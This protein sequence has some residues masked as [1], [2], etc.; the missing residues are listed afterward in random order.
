VYKTLNNISPGMLDY[1]VEEVEKKLVP[2]LQKL[3]DF[4]HQMGI[5]VIYTKFSAFMQDG[6]DLPAPLQKQNKLAKEFLGDI[7]YPHISHESSEIIANLKP[8]EVRDWVLQK[9][10]SGTFISTRLDNYLRNMGIETVLVCGVVTHFCVEST[11]REAADYGFQTI[12]VDDCCA[13]WTPDLHE[14]TLQIFELLYGFVM[15]HEKV[16]KKLSKTLNKIKP[17]PTTQ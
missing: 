14:R 9:N 16:I 4:C 13:G 17:T 2:N 3:I 7:P 10:T 5:Q 15:P 12:I 8:D 11:A 6:S 1:F